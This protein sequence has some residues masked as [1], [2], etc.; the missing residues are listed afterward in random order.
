[1]I[2]TVCLNS[3]SKKFTENCI[4]ADISELRE[5]GG[6]VIWADVTDPTSRDFEEPFAPFVLFCGMH[7]LKENQAQDHCRLWPKLSP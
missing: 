1:V 4:A 3:N 7:T 6:N 5:V 2:T